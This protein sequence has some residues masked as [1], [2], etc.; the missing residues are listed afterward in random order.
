MQPKP[1][2][3]KRTIVHEMIE[4]WIN[5][6][7][8]AFFLVAALISLWKTGAVQKWLARRADQV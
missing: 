3:W 4:Y 5:F 8:L 7:Y 6:L 2:G 1:A